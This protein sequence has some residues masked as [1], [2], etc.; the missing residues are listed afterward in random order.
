L[1]YAKYLPG[2]LKKSRTHPSRDAH[3]QPAADEGRHFAPN[4]L[5]GQGEY[6]E[7][8]RPDLIMMDMILPMKSGLELIEEI[9]P[10]PGCE[11][12]PIVM[13]S[14]TANPLTLREA[15]KLGANCV[16]R[17]PG[18]WGEYFK[19]LETCYAFWCGVAELPHGS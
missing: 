8:R 14:G 9:R 13:I 11:L 3:S 6:S 16:M 10:I 18:D 4:Y 7:P 15:Y 5:R 12:I 17:K 1:L 19:K 2:R